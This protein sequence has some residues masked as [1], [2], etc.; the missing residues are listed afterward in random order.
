MKK[1]ETDALKAK[2]T[3]KDSTAVKASNNVTMRDHD[4]LEVL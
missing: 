1:M 4:S 2:V 3:N